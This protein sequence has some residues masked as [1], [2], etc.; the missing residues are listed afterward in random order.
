[1]LTIIGEV[2]LSLP[3]LLGFVPRLKDQAPSK[4]HNNRKRCL[5]S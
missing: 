4:C 1:M 3:E 2:K 5:T